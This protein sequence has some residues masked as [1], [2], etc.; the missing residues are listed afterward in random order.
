MRVDHLGCLIESALDRLQIKVIEI[1][2]VER[3]GT[4]KSRDRKKGI[5]LGRK[6][7]GRDDRANQP[8]II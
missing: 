7:M 4:K 1:K 3:T 2:K 6:G 8:D 5:Y